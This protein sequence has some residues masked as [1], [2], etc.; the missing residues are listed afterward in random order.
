MKRIMRQK[1]GA[2][3]AIAVVVI[4]IVCTA[5]VRMFR[6]PLSY[7]IAS[8]SIDSV[9]DQQ[10][11]A[12]IALR[13]YNK[14]QFNIKVKPAT[15]NI[16]V[17]H[18]LIG[19]GVISSDA[20]LHVKESTLVPVSVTLDLKSLSL[21]SSRHSPG[22]SIDFVLD[23]KIKTV[24]LNHTLGM[25]I[26]E[27]ISLNLKKVISDYL[28][29]RFMHA[30]NCQIAGLRLKSAD[31]TNPE[32]SIRLRIYNVLPFTYH[33]YGIHLTAYRI[34]GNKPL[35]YLNM[36]DTV[37][38]QP[39]MPA[40]IGLSAYIDYLN[41]VQQANLSDLFHPDLRLRFTGEFTVSIEGNPFITPIEIIYQPSL[42]AFKR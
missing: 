33:L 15:L 30:S 16:Y 34:T 42:S 3:L 19:V 10:V 18:H 35:S 12:H 5:F 21:L 39:H 37:V 20:R 4:F 14:G 27:Q 17:A 31:I 25:H 7:D 38:S 29:S 28:T 24:V 23:G 40:T 41:L 11:I 8:V 13:V 36:S 2:F 9:S 26:N 32:L 1:T 6:D 22:D